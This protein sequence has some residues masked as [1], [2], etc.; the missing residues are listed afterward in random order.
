MITREFVDKI[1]TVLG[2][3]RDIPAPDSGTSAQVMAWMMDEY[4]KLHGD[5][6]AVVTGKPLSLGGS[7]GRESATGQGVVQMYREAAPLLGLKPETTRVVLQGFGNVGAW[8]GRI[9]A[10]LGCSIVGVGNT[11]GAIHCAAG[12]DPDLLARHLE[13]GGE[14]VEFDG[15]GRA[16]VDVV[17]PEELMALECDVLIPAALG[18][19]IHA[20]NAGSIQARL[21]IEGANNPTTPAADEILLDKEVLVVPDVLA[22]AGGVIV[23]YFEWVQNIQHVRWHAR[24]VDEQL[25]ST[26]HRAYGEVRARAEQDAAT[27]RLAAYELAIERV[28]EA[29]RMRGFG[30]YV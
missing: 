28:A 8:A 6:P 9:I 24:R 26:L 22:N 14:L 7:P 19:A 27:P 29:M 15:G 25:E 16:A 2:P 3:M 4:G 5:T 10:R 17:A 30:G 21:V 11:S 23:S 13:N 18:G 12:I 1:A 20:A